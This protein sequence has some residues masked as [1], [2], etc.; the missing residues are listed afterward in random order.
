VVS[1]ADHL[2]ARCYRVKEVEVAGHEIGM[3]GRF[4]HNLLTCSTITACRSG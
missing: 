1:F 3:V 2:P 4:G